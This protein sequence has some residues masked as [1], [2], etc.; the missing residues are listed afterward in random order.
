MQAR[1]KVKLFQ[2]TRTGG[3]EILGEKAYASPAE[4]LSADI[5]TAHRRSEFL[6]DVAWWLSFSLKKCVC[7]DKMLS[8]N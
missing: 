7:V 5:V 8:N 3:V 1:I 4:I 6:P 2:L